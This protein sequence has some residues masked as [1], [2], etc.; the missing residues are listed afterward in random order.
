LI[1]ESRLL[2]FSRTRANSERP[3]AFNHESRITNQQR[4][5][6]H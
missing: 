3:P 6:N 1:V 5:D 2:I 4:F